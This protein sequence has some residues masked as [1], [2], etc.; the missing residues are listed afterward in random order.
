M[1]RFRSFHLT[2]A[3]YEQVLL[4]TDQSMMLVRILLALLN[5]ILDL[6]GAKLIDW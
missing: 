1:V 3:M 4:V 2:F 6:Y 5:S